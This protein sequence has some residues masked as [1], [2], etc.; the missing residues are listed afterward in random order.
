MVHGNI[1]WHFSGRDESI[2][3]TRVFENE[4]EAREALIVSLHELGPMKLLKGQVAQ[5][6][7]NELVWSEYVWAGLG[8]I[9]CGTWR[10][11]RGLNIWP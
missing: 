1:W 4:Q 11:N 10:S 3:D 9:K 7:P 5:F 6:D 2:G 8:L